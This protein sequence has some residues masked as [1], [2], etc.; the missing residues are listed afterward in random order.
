MEK[1]P[2]SGVSAKMLHQIFLLTG[3]LGYRF[4]I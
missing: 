3:L 2:V 1:I 4:E